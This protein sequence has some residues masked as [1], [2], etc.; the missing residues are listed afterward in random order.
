MG[1]NAVVFIDDP[2][3]T[4]KVAIGNTLKVVKYSDLQLEHNKRFFERLFAEADVYVV[5]KVSPLPK[6]KFEQFIEGIQSG[7][8][9][10]QAEAEAEVEAP[11]VRKPV[12]QRA[13]QRQVPAP[14]QRSS[15]L[16]SAAKTHIIID[17]LYVGEGIR[18]DKTLKRALA[19]APNTAINL[20]LLDKE[21]V[22]NSVIL[23]QLMR[24]N[25]LVPCTP[26]EAAKL[27]QLADQKAEEDSKT[28]LEIVSDGTSGS[29]ER[30]A[31][32]VRRGAVSV[33]DVEEI[34]IEDD[35][36]EPEDITSTGQLTMDQML[37]MT[38]AAD[39][40]QSPA[41]RRQLESRPRA[42]SAT[43]QPLSRVKIRR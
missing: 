11:Q 12:T 8:V 9:G 23:Q 14:A 13:P 34:K 33:D 3:Q 30:Y 19:I 39:D 20:A 25:I 29:A 32:G 41:P 40:G 5:D 7:E 15:Y 37:R 24:D 10:P 27:Q 28:T 18:G 36:K 42:T 21:A 35:G 6:E 1:K 38:G 17:D 22:E 43:G 26:V 31:E 16:R 4:V 2:E